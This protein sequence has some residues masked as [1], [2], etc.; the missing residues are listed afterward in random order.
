MAI[1]KVSYH[2][3]QSVDINEESIPITQAQ[4]LRKKFPSVYVC[5]FLAC[6]YG[7]L[8]VLLLSPRCRR[9]R[10]RPDVL[11]KVF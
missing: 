5:T 11:V 8:V 3:A 4:I 1:L 6:L 7:V 10:P 2:I 9:Q